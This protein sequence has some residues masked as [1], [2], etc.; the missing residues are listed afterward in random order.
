M[1]IQK[2]ILVFA[3]LTVFTCTAAAQGQTQELTATVSNSN[4]TAVTWSLSPNIG[5]ISSSGVYTAPASVIGSQLVTVTA[6]SVADPSKTASATITVR[7]PLRRRIT[8]QL[9]HS[10]S[11]N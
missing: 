1:S 2:L 7:G 6:V 4:N 11:R 3:A 9:R 5:S 10:N 8:P